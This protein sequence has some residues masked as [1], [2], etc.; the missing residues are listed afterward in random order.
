MTRAPRDKS[1]DKLIASKMGF[2]GSGE[3]TLSEKGAGLA[4]K[5]EEDKR[6]NRRHDDRHEEWHG[7]SVAAINLF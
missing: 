5:L 4:P 1:G 2:P 3:L 6:A 7:E